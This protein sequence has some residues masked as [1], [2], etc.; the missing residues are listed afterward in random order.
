M[1]NTANTDTMSRKEILEWL[2][3]IATATRYSVYD[4]ND[5]YIGRVE[6]DIEIEIEIAELNKE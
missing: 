2:L 6:N 1:P 3:K 5:I 4:G